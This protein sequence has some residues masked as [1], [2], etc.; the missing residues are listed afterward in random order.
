MA[1]R[2]EW[3]DEYSVGVARFD[4]SHKNLCA[5]INRMYADI[6]QGR[7]IETQKSALSSLLG[8]ITSHFADEEQLMAE[9]GYPDIVSHK[10]EHETF[11]D[12][13]TLFNES[14]QGGPAHVTIGLLDH[15]VEW[16]ERHITGA[17][18]KY[19]AFFNSKGVT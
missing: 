13:L 8:H 6:S 10:Q 3:K 12:S 19:Q 17:D 1:E 7:G 5:M 11:W 14:C 16:L 18:K 4:E 9:Y 15:Q 2:I